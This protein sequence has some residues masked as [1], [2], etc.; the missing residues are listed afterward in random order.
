M[1]EN[2]RL[3]C[4]V[5][6]ARICVS[7]TERMPS[8]ITLKHGMMVY[9]VAVWPE[10]PLI[11]STMS[12]SNLCTDHVEQEVPSLNP[13]SRDFEE[14]NILGSPVQPIDMD[15]C[16]DEVTNFGELCTKLQANFSPILSWG[17]GLIVHEL[18]EE[19]TVES[20]V[21]YDADE[22]LCENF[23]THNMM[24]NEKKS[25]DREILSKESE[26]W[27]DIREIPT[28]TLIKKCQLKK[29]GDLPPGFPSPEK[30]WNV[31]GINE[32]EKRCILKSL[33]G[34]TRSGIYS[35][36]ETK[37]RQMDQWIVREL[38]NWRL[39]G[40]AALDSI[41][42]SGGILISWNDDEFEKMDVDIGKFSISVQL[43]NR[44]DNFRWVLSAVYGPV[45]HDLKAEFFNELSKVFSL[46][47]L[48]IIF[49][50]DMNQV[51]DPS[52]RKGARRLT[53]QMSEFSNKIEDLELVDLPLKGGR[54]TFKRGNGSG[55]L[56]ES[57]IDRFL[58]S[59]SIFR[60]VANIFQK[61]LPWS[62]SD[63]RPILLEHRVVQL[64]CRPF[65]FENKWLSRV[66]FLPR[67]QEWWRTQAPLGSTSSKLF[68]NLKNLRNQ[69]KSW[70][71]G[72]RA[73]FCAKVDELCKKINIIDEVEEVREL[74]AEEVSS[75]IFQVSNLLEL[76]KEEE[77]GARQRSRATWIRYGDKNTKFFHC[78]S[79]EQA[80]NNAI[81]S[82][83]LEGVVHDA[84]FTEEEVE[85]AVMGCGS[86]KAP[87]SDGFTLAF[88]KKAWPFLKIDIMEAIEH[89][90]QFSSFDKSW[91][92]SLIY[93]IRKTP[94]TINAKNFRP[95]SLV[96]SFYKI[97]SK[98]LANKLRGVL[99]LVS[100][101]NQMAFIKGRQIF[102]ASLIANECIDSA[103]FKRDKCAF[104]KLD[105]E[106]AY[107]HVNWDFF[108]DIMTRMENANLI[109]GVDYGVRRSPFVI[110]HLLFAD[111]TLCMIQDTRRNFKHLR[112]ILWLFGACSGLRV[113]L[114]K[115]EIFFS[116]SVSN[117][118]KMALASILGFVVGSF[119][120]TYLGMLLGVKARSKA[121]WDS[122]IAKM[123]RKLPI[124]KSKMISKGGRFI[125]INSALAS[126]PTYMMSLF[127]MPKSVA[128]K[129]ERI[130]C[131][132][133]WGSSESSFC[134]LV[135]W[136]KVKKFKDQG[137]LGIQDLI[138]FNTTLLS[139][140][141]SIYSLE[142]T[143]LWATMIKC[144]YGIDWSGWFT[145][146]INHVVGCGIWSGISVIWKTFREQCKFLVGDGFRLVFGM[147]DATVKD[148][149]DMSSNGFSRRIRYMRRL[150][151]DEL[152]LYDKVLNLVG[153]KEVN[154]SSHDIMRWQDI[155]TFKFS[156]YY[157]LI[158]ENAPY[159]FIWEKLWE[160][161][162]PSKISF[163]GW[164]VMHGGILTD[165]RCMKKGCVMASRCRMCHKEVE[166]TPHLLLHCDGVLAIWSLYGI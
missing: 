92:S 158:A 60:G 147:T 137:G 68:M 30:P 7:P 47:N 29:I 2:T 75:R 152:A 27:P 104:V 79:K 88:F 51:R 160:S 125:L 144:K 40:W 90:Y 108:Y 39:C 80:R 107:D 112:D 111:D 128:V 84:R 86:D 69:I 10:W 115:Y 129:M 130:I 157:S 91:N 78:V 56:S 35:F 117:R 133:L 26:V 45:S 145:K 63:H 83:S 103:N 89:F 124:W 131:K 19:E 53:S 52:E 148:M 1:D 132:F 113:N 58:V 13:P 95:I 163:F 134:H 70:Y 155:D 15:K 143:S 121:S 42:A 21:E 166:S 100:S 5:G 67:V 135:R 12:T 106:K 122:T 119:P 74:L 164:S 31:C 97:V 150:N 156:H 72:E 57:R 4:E 136:D 146:P 49:A 116:N 149:F 17:V 41:G 98:C 162:L 28:M 126:M 96:S 50:G 18:S 22:E 6:W 101:A 159:N 153:R 48:P 38:C 142:P 20:D 114:S 61:V 44:G 85:A 37:I 14:N 127:L 82:I 23:C 46:W 32:R 77:I 138:S 105:I 102:D 73:T 81:N 36:C 66:E 87:G 54:F 110:S 140:W 25:L 154:P 118:R 161:K 9:K 99:E 151:A 43:R 139:K 165:D 24:L 11:M 34:S 71:V 3:K 76:C 55:G 64:P 120:S 16:L 94:G 141:C 59:E 93:L 62:C 33:V 65:R 8:S 109:R 123:E